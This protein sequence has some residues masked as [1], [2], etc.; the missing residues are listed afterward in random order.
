MAVFWGKVDSTFFS[1]PVQKFSDIFGIR[2]KNPGSETLPLCTVSD[3]RVVFE[4]FGRNPDTNKS[5]ESAA[6]FR[7]HDICTQ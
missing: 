5:S 2:D 7:N 3:I 6:E 4:T 1:L